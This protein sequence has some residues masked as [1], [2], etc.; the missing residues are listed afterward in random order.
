MISFQ[1]EQHASLVSRIADALNIF[2]TS[3]LCYIPCTMEEIA[4]RQVTA[5][6][7]QWC[8]NLLK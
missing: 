1:Y 8:T 5:T 4:P 3:Y 7:D 2:C 6:A